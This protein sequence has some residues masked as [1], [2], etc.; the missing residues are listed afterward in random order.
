[1]TP[2]AGHG[3]DFS[4]FAGLGD[5]PGLG[6]VSADVPGD[7]TVALHVAVRMPDDFKAWH[8]PPGLERVWP[9][10]PP[11][12]LL[13]PLEVSVDVTCRPLSERSVSLAASPE[14]S[15]RK[16]KREGEEAAAL[17]L[18]EPTDGLPLINPDSH[19][20]EDVVTAMARKLVLQAD[21]AGP[22]AVKGSAGATS[23]GTEVA[24]AFSLGEAVGQRL[25]ATALSPATRDRVLRAVL[26]PALPPWVPAGQ[27]PA[28]GQGDVP[29]PGLGP[30]HSSGFIVLASFLRGLA[31]TCAGR[32][33]TRI[34][35]FGN[36]LLDAATRL[37]LDLLHAR[38]KRSLT[39]RDYCEYGGPLQLASHA[40][41]VGRHPSCPVSQFVRHVLGHLLANCPRG[42][43]GR[44]RSAYLEGVL[45]SLAW[46]PLALRAV[47][48]PY[49]DDFTRGVAMLAR[50]ET[51]LDIAHLGRGLAS[52]LGGLCS[53]AM[54]VRVLQI[55][56]MN[57]PPSAESIRLGEMAMAYL[58]HVTGEP[59]AFAAVL[60]RVPHLDPFTAG[61]IVFRVAVAEGRSGRWTSDLGI[62]P[63][64]SRLRLCLQ[65]AQGLEPNRQ[66]AVLQGLLGATYQLRGLS[67]EFERQDQGMGQLLDTVLT[68]MGPAGVALRPVVKDLH[69][70]VQ[71]PQHAFAMA[72]HSREL[73]FVPLYITQALATYLQV[74]TRRFLSDT[75]RFLLSSR[76]KQPGSWALLVRLATDHPS[77]VTPAGLPAVRALLLDGL[78]SQLEKPPGQ[79]RPDLSPTKVGHGVVKALQT[80]YAHPPLRSTLD[81]RAEI[82]ALE[83]FRHSQVLTPVVAALRES[84]PISSMKGAQ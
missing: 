77:G 71:D 49:F 6:H 28:V 15:N 19:N 64:K 81:V 38:G 13:K 21:L 78:A 2:T 11:S 51:D 83:S 26:Q 75:V 33:A 40:L 34:A 59:L 63:E 32:E 47:Q 73:P 31:R 55:L 12:A 17:S 25:G 8:F 67:G 20:L 48:S 43:V 30:L 35:E 27:G 46:M 50:D 58:G 69:H 54:H 4:A 44:A 10:D 52:A 61:R 80:L 23:P 74:S 66:R 79:A 1:M 29:G 9:L 72:R 41:G 45:A 70:M 39:V 22:P 84:F 56:G 5:L 62:P 3:P 18:A 57:C 68:D 16:R 53:E 7:D 82:A 24:L 14:S 37:S 36:A 65:V 60:Q 76:G 42:V